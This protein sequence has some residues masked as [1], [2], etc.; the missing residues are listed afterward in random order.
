MCHHLRA[1]AAAVSAILL[2]L[3]ALAGFAGTDLFLPMAGR[4]AG[5]YPSNWYTTVWIHNPGLDAA[6]AAISFLERN[7]ANLSPPAVE[8]LVA[9][10]A[11]EKIENVV[12]S[13][14]QRQAFGALR[15]TC[16]TQKLVVTSRV[17]SK[18][19]GAD[20]TASLGQDF[21]GVPAA[22]AIGLGERAGLLGVHQTVP[23]ADSEYRFNF[24]FVETTGHTVTVRVTVYDEAGTYLEAKDFQVREHSQRQAAFKDHFPALS[25]LNARIDA[26]VVS[27]SGRVIAYGSLI[28]NGSQDPTTFEMTYDDAVLGAATLIH[29]GSLVGD[30]TAGSPLGLADQ[31]VTIA[32][33]ATANAPSAVAS[34]GSDPQQALA[35][36]DA[37]VAMGGTLQWQPLGSGDITGVAAGAGLAG[38]G[39]AGAVTVS[40]ANGGITAAMLGPGAVGSGALLDG[41]VASADLANGAVTPAK[42]GTQGAASGDVLRYDG[43]G[44][45]WTPDA[46]QLPFSRSVSDGQAALALTNSGGGAAV[47][48]ASSGEPALVGTHQYGTQGSVG[49]WNAGIVG[50]GGTGNP[51][52]IGQSGSAEA[53]AG[54]S[55]TGTGVY[56]AHTATGSSGSLGTADAGARGDGAGA[57]TGVLGTSTSGTGVSGTSAS[58]FGVHG[59]SDGGIAVRADAGTDT[60]VY[61]TT[62]TGFAGVHAAN[63]TGIGLFAESASH[64]AVQAVA[65]S[66]GKSGVYA[67]NLNASGWAGYFNGRVHVAGTLSKAAGAFTIDHPLDPENRILSHSFVESP[68]MMDIYNGNVTLDGDGR[69]WVELPEWF[70]ALNRE[71]RYQLTCVGAFAPIYVA[72]RV[73]G[74]RFLIAGGSPGLE[75]SWQVTGIRHDPYAEANRIRVDEAKREEDRGRYLHPEVYGASLDDA[76]GPRAARGPELP[77]RGTPARP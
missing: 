36:P 38:G 5:V 30:G 42:L 24:G 27:G 33:L 53:V 64:D 46:F 55:S 75:V 61:A 57:G 73:A 39:S 32:K 72:E 43:V 3:P 25:L 51:G 23:A 59:H 1:A 14:F 50:N 54:W 40:V 4:Q 65:G 71:Y 69:A 9:P 6:T 76:A 45:F 21:A 26:E 8:V 31:A 70:E 77:A 63:V 34:A 16:P 47:S 56:G 41:G 62:W 17:Y 18:A 20:E 2:S 15:V 67:Q 35:G 37:L 10:G 13:L 12:E 48:G 49:V 28:A 60:G 11:T 19:A 68:D 7:T 44:V 52:V 58:G 66:A 22:F 29:D 74:N